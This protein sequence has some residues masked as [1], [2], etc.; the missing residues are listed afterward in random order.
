[1]DYSLINSNELPGD[2]GIV[3]KRSR[4]KFSPG[5]VLSNDPS[6][7][8][9]SYLPEARAR[10]KRLQDQAAAIEAAEPD[11]SALQDYA[12]QQGQAGDSAMLNALAAQ[13]AGENFAPVQTQFL[14]RAAAAKEP[15]K[16]GGGMLTPDGQFV[17][18]P[19][20][21]R[22]RELTRFDR[23][24]GAERDDILAAERAE[25][26]RQDRL[27]RE[28][29]DARR[30]E[31]DYQFRV[32]GRA[33]QRAI[34][35]AARASTQDNQTFTRA[36]TLRGEYGKRADKIREGTR[37]AETVMT[38]LTDPTIAR[39]PTKQ[40]S[41]VFAFGKML[42]PESV[43]RESEYALISNA[44]GAFESLLQKP[45]QILTGARLTPS[46]LASMRQ[47]AQQLYS[48]SATRADELNDYYAEMARRNRL[49]VDDVLP[50]GARRGAPAPAGRPAAGGQG[51][52]PA[53]Q[54]VDPAVWR[55]MTPEE[56]ALWK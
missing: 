36:T 56:R 18:D 40:V 49:N 51:I 25:Q 13:F 27:Y 34:A 6:S 14:K 20:A 23:L 16:V 50:P 15:M 7:T 45:D 4:A 2:P 39:D 10:L 33:T 12:R 26:Q 37:H 22:E 17:R 19:F 48:G 1:M 55:A 47:V 46:Q 54:G 52:P 38:L 53:P 42:D 11:I 30:D 21:T 31:R 44:R 41:L 28:Q 32:D 3:L 29:E 43:V 9:A 5:G 35:D 24:I 8:S